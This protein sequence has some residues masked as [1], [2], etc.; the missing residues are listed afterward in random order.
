VIDGVARKINS[1]NKKKRTRKDDGF[2]YSEGGPKFRKP[3]NLKKA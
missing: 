1:R 3:K 2:V